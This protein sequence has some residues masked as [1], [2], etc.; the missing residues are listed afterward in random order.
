VHR[1]PWRMPYGYTEVTY[2]AGESVD[3]ARLA[4][5]AVTM[6]DSY[7]ATLADDA[8]STDEPQYDGDP[9]PQEAPPAFVRPTN[10]APRQTA[11]PSTHGG[12]R[13]GGSGDTS[14]PYGVTLRCPEHGDILRPSV[15]NKDMD[16]IEELGKEI[17]ASW[18]HTG[19]DGKTC[20]VYQSR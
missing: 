2:E 3:F 1:I 8:Q 18:F 16:W 11:R 5:E 15:R 14:N 13:G 6:E 10:S 20:S 12:S 17:P 4:L 9:G 7:R 19:P